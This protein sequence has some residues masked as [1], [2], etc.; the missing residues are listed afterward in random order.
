VDDV[1]VAILVCGFGGSLI[2][3]YF[4]YSLGSDSRPSSVG[5]TMTSDEFKR[6]VAAM[7]KAQ[8][9]FYRADVGTPD[10]SRWLEESKRLEREVDQALKDDKQQEL[11]RE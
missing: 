9:S 4:G 10:R 3:F 11:F 2:G 5:K 8:K 1:S 7:R 6:L